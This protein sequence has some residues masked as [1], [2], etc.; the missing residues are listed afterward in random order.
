MLSKVET[1]NVSVSYDLGGCRLSATIS[2]GVRQT[3]GKEVIVLTIT[4][5]STT[6]GSMD[7]LFQC[8]DM[9]HRN[10]VLGFV[11][12]TSEALQKKWE[13]IR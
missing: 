1:A 13:R 3:D 8:L 11:R 2:P 6:K 10:A 5:W 9:C 7:D 12:F 4:G